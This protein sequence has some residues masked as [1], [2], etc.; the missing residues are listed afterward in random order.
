MNLSFFL[1][2]HFSSRVSQYIMKCSHYLSQTKQKNP[3][4]HPI[5]HRAIWN[6]LGVSICCIFD[7]PQPFLDIFI[8]FCSSLNSYCMH[9]NI[10]IVHLSDTQ[11]NI[12][13][14][15]F[16][17]PIS[18]SRTIL[19]GI[20]HKEKFLWMKTYEIFPKGVNAALTSSVVISG[21]RSPTN[22]WKWS[23]VMEKQDKIQDPL[24]GFG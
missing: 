3:Q 22:T 2:F 12:D 24:I 11:C 5:T 7:N 20:S 15:G 4:Q 21:L 18:N 17:S 19:Y 6:R 1:F 9:V 10:A 23:E 8:H 13:Y 16:C 14:L